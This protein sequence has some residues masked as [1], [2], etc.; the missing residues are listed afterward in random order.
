MKGFLLFELDIDR[1]LK[2]YWMTKLYNQIG[3]T[4]HTHYAMIFFLK[5]LNS[6]KNGN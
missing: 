2:V 4:R 6:F 5:L 1:V 3:L